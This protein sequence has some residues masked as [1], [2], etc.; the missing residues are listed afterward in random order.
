[1]KDNATNQ[2][3]TNKTESLEAITQAKESATNQINTNKTESLEAITQA[4]ESANNEI[5]EVKKPIIIKT[6]IFLRL[7]K[8]C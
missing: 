6:L 7:N 4:K 2:I 3:N 5:S 8:A 1:A